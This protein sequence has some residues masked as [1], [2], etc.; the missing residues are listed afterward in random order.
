[1]THDEFLDR[2]DEHVKAG[3]G[4]LVVCPAHA[5]RSPSLS[6]SEGEDGRILLSCKAG[7]TAT[8][9]VKSMGLGL[10]DLFPGNDTPEYT[11]TFEAVYQYEDADGKVLFEQ[12]RKPGKKFVQRHYDP[13]NPDAKPDGWVWNLDGVQRVLYHL[14]DLMDGIASGRGVWIAEGEKD[15]DALI[16]AG[17]VATCNPGGAGPGKFRPE[18][19]PLFQGVAIT[20][21]ADKDEPGRTH[22]ARLKE[23]LSIF[24]SDVRILQA[25]VGKDAADHLAADLTCDEFVPVR[26]SPRKGVVTAKQLAEAAV[27]S[28]DKTELDIPGYLMLDN[29][30]IVMRNGRMYVVGAYTSDGKSTLFAQVTRRVCSVYGVRVGYFTLEMPE[31]DIR[32]KILS[33]RGIPLQMLEEPWRLKGDPDMLATFNEAVE[34]L[35]DWN[36][37]VIF[38]TK[39]TA[40]Y[41]VQTSIER[42]YDFVVVDHI[43]RIAWGGERG[44]F[45]AEVQKLTNISVDL[46]IPVLL[47]CQLRKTSRGKDFVSYPKPSLQEFRETSVI[48]DDAA[49]ALALWRQRD[50]QGMKFVNNGGA[51]LTILKNRYT[52]GNHDAAGTSFFPKFDLKTQLFD[53]GQRATLAQPEEDMYDDGYDD[54]QS[55]EWSS[56][57]D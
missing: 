6:V 12:I 39:A 19:A 3:S 45:E 56:L 17:K 8:Q 43:H 49:M 35:S 22:A 30:P 26:E 25:K 24:A 34:E 14:P 23:M 57:Y 41:I 52:T 51:E 20:I 27:E 16:A 44:R 4:V 36:L 31:A 7:C 29:C 40:D 33:H 48:G 2:F 42:E 46:N 50:A 53:I 55:S 47:A 21:V 11:D 10:K 9:V 18:W 13:T 32:N 28:L 37:D 1:M 5:D 54:Y 38:N 15:V